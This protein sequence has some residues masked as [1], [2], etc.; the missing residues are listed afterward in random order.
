MNGQKKML[1]VSVAAFPALV[2]GAVLDTGQ[3]PLPWVPET[4]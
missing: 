2:V 4:D 3:Q 1:A